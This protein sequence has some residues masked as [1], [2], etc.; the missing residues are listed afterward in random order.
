MKLKKVIA[1]H[2]VDGPTG[3]VITI[4][5][6]GF[7]GVWIRVSE[8]YAYDINAEYPTSSEKMQEIINAIKEVGDGTAE[9]DESPTWGL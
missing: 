9:E 6:S 5:P 4:I 3:E 1:Y 2:Q 8:D 7:S